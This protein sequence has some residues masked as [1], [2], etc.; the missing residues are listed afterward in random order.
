MR[1]S[2]KNKWINLIND[3]YQLK[4]L[5]GTVQEIAKKYN[6]NAKGFSILSDINIFKYE[7]R[8]K[9]IVYT[10]PK[11][12]SVDYIIQYLDHCFELMYREYDTIKNEK[13]LRQNDLIDIEVDIPPFLK[14][15]AE[16]AIYKNTIT[17]LQCNI[18]RLNASVM[19]LREDI[20]R[21]DIALLQ[22][23]KSIF[24]KIKNIFQ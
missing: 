7:K 12:H 23:K 20:K 5:P 16:E 11:F 19:E 8:N 1:A 4:S 21:K 18:K 24:A 14:S 22:K 13:K 17:N 9:R 6:L 2:T 3:L 15:S 10:N